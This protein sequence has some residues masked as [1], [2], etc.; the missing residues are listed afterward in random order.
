MAIKTEDAILVGVGSLAVIGIGYGIYLAVKRP[1]GYD[2][3]DTFVAIFNVEH[4]TFEADFI[5]RVA[6]G[7]KRIFGFD[8][9]EGLLWEEVVRVGGHP[10]WSKIT[11]VVMK[12]QLPDAV[13]PGEYDAEASIRELDGSLIVRTISDKV[14]TV[15]EQ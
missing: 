15:R 1:P 4:K 13:D 3:G 12:C 10:E 11:P 9:V 7:H 6:L 14:I 5:F 8:E 2:P